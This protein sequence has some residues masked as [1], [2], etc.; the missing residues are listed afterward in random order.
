MYLLGR[1]RAG[2][3]VQKVIE[4]GV[5]MPLPLVGALLVSSFLLVKRL[6]QELQQVYIPAI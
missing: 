5:R 3:K 4:V 2:V 6:Q 1:P